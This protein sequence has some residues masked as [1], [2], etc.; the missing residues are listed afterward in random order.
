M[1]TTRYIILSIDRSHLDA[2]S[3]LLSSLSL[4][5]LYSYSPYSVP[6]ARP[7]SPSFSLP[8]FTYVC[9]YVHRS[10]RPPDHPSA[11]PRPRALFQPLLSS[12][13]IAQLL[14]YRA[15]WRATRRKNKQEKKE[16]EHV[17]RWMKVFAIDSVKSLI[18]KNNPVGF[19]FF[20][21]SFHSV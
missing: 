11:Y 16:T 15:A 18:R 9:T 8:L 4:S 21:R 10:S 2:S 3:F 13:W 1:V 6:Y 17:Q 12:F 14:R 19:V 7:S 20:Q 5:Y